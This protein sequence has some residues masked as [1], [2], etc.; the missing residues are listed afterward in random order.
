MT[1]KQAFREYVPVPS[2]PAD[3]HD[4]LRTIVSLV[5]IL[6]A[7]EERLPSLKQIDKRAHHCAALGYVRNARKMEEKL[8][9]ELTDPK[10][11]YMLTNAVLG[12]LINQMSI[13]EAVQSLEQGQE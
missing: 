4:Y 8:L 13:A 10:G 5:V 3:T 12:S 7:I 11:M 2:M 6:K 9:S 1:S